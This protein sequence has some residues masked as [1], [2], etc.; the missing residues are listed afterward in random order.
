MSDTTYSSGPRRD[1]A[2]ATW[3]GRIHSLLLDQQQRWRQGECPTLE[4]YLE[5][6]PS[7]RG[8]IEDVLTLLY[9]EVVL[10]ER[11][12]DQPSAEEYEQRF[13]EWAKE[14]REHFEIHDAFPSVTLP[15]HPA[16]RSKPA[17][18]QGYEILGFLGRGGMAV[19]YEARQLALDRRVALKMILG[20][21]NARPEERARFRAEAL[22]VASLKHPNI[23]QIHEVIEHEGRLFLALEL[24][25]GGSLAQKLDG[26]PLPPRTAVQLVEPL[27]RAMHAVHQQGIIHRDL[28]PSNILLQVDNKERA[29]D[30][31]NQHED[32]RP[33]SLLSTD[34]CLLSTILKIADFGV[35]KRLND[36]GAGHTRTGDLIGTPSYMAP[37][38]VAGRDRTTSATDIYGLGAILYE[39][40]TGRPPFLGETTLATLQQVQQ[41]EPVAPS[42]LQP[43][44]PRDLETVVLKCLQKE[45][46]RRYA[47]AAALADDL[48]CFLKGLPIKARPTPWHERLAKWAKRRP[49]VA[50]LLAGLA[51]IT[52]LGLAGISWQWRRAERGREEAIRAGGLE[53]AARADAENRL[54]ASEIAQASLDLAASQSL[55]AERILEFC[56][57]RD[58]DR[59]H[60][61]WH[62]LKRQC[63]RHVLSFAGHTQP[64]TWLAYSPDG[65]MLASCSGIWNGTVHG[66]VK[67]WDVTTGKLL[68]DLRGPERTVH[69]VAF[70]PQSGKLLAAASIDG[71][72]WV[73]DLDQPA[74]APRRLFLN[75]LAYCVAFH[76]DGQTIAAGG[77]DGAFQVW[78]LANWQS[79]GRW[80][81]HTDAV[82]DLSFS[83]DGKLLATASRDGTV[84]VLA[85]DTF[86]LLHR[87]FQPRET[88]RLAFSPDSRL[89]ASGAYDGT[90]KIWDLQRQA[91]LLLEHHLGWR[92]LFSVA[93]S[94]DG[95]RLAC[96]TRRNGVR[97]WSTRGQF[98]EA[99]P[100]SGTS[101]VTFALAFSPDAR[102]MATA[103]DDHV[104][105]VWDLAPV[106]EPRA[107]SAH[108]TDVSAI[109]LSPNGKTLAIVGGRNWAFGGRNGSS[110][111]RLRNYPTA[112]V[113]GEL[114]GHK[115]WPGCIAFRP[116]G[117]Q[118]ASGDQDGKT[119]LW[120]TETRKQE[121]ILERHQNTVLGVVYSP[122]GAVLAT[123]GADQTVRLWRAA[124]GESRGV[125]QHPASV[126]AVCYSADGR[127]L[128][129]GAAD[130][131]IRV[132]DT[133]TWHELRQL[134]GHGACVNSI[135]F[136]PESH[137]LVSADEGYELHFW[138]ADTGDDLTVQVKPPGIPGDGEGRSDTAVSERRETSLAFSPD[139]RRLAFVGH[140]RP[141]Q[142]WD[143]DSRRLMLTLAEADYVNNHNVIFSRDGRQI[144]VTCQS[145]L[146][147]W[148]SSEYDQ[149]SRVLAVQE[150]ASSWHMDQAHSALQRCDWFTADFHV[151][152]YLEANPKEA[153]WYAQR[154][155][156]RAA[157]GQREKADAD[158]MKAIALAPV[159][160]A[161]WTLR[162]EAC[163]HAKRWED[164]DRAFLAALACDPGNARTWYLR[165]VANLGSG[166]EPGY[167]ATCEAM[168][169]YF[170]E[171]KSAGDANFVISAVAAV[172]KWPDQ[173]ALKQLS[174]IAAQLGAGNERAIAAACYRAGR[175]RETVQNLTT[176]SSQ[177][178]P[179]AWDMLFH[180]MASHRLKE[181][182]QAAVWLARARSWIDE[183]ER[184]EDDPTK[185]GF[186]RWYHWNE[187]VETLAL[188]REAELVR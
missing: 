112:T 24:M 14:I 103:R 29:A 124:T 12:G 162:G 89:L 155:L 70:H 138:D 27:V 36:D 39:L 49:A 150:L 176:A 187:R 55:N 153:V 34:Y 59:C 116:D 100:P 57:Q 119:I 145:I 76:P 134:T 84:V 115:G 51:V 7:L 106:D 2:E 13:P 54:Y 26:A 56:R 137:L 158:H 168:I 80:Q 163:V 63:Q 32:H 67:V 117:N 182:A 178:R 74:R 38:Q 101:G 147:F 53:A 58:P 61:E 77:S 10:R 47:D 75:A 151:S 130:R 111:I 82:W 71:N 43:G 94:P 62:Y 79:L 120:N 148:D 88:M 146:K 22:A 35:A 127:Y 173:K 129:T 48:Q 136:H 99:S 95:Q 140:N 104:I 132:W 159:D 177:S 23:V 44:C 66:E 97:I 98:E 102:W 110:T 45:P 186:V 166:N 172:S 6:Y 83:P 86:K 105:R 72:V 175:H 167:R 91:T 41:N 46:G 15:E 113:S 164:A 121:A 52:V 73:W 20:G 174:G 87:L 118:L 188:L 90:V 37:E 85:A 139:G 107:V 17:A 21:E 3:Q 135:A 33:F 108:E 65:K 5:K 125:L 114:V 60:W 42:R 144:L 128:A 184:V 9:H 96:C 69:R 160:A 152:R 16:P 181:N 185:E 40:I 25:E 64:I 8:R 31:N 4:I 165:A 68:H 169:R 30:S 109:A 154:G 149:A 157:R 133:S 141:A 122:D 123:A 171:T 142:I 156:T 18:P 131:L 1:S 81:G 19:V 28:K 143:V 183:A 180:A 11:R 179:R 78:N 92:N 170:A 50:G 161:I 126:H 93:F